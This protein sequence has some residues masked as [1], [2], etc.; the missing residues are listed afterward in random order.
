MLALTTIIAMISLAYGFLPKF[1]CQY[2]IPMKSSPGFSGGIMITSKADY[3]VG[4]N[5]PE[6]VAKYFE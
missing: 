4:K 1:P 3:V 5:I 6:E 2:S